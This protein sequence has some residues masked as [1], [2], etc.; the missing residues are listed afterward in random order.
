MHSGPT[1]A[2]ILTPASWHDWV[3]VLLVSWKCSLSES[4]DKMKKK[5]AHVY[6]TFLFQSEILSNKLLIIS[7]LVLA[8]IC[9]RIFLI[10]NLLT[11]KPERSPVEIFSRLLHKILAGSGVTALTINRKKN[12]FW[13]FA[14]WPYPKFSDMQL[15][16]SVDTMDL[17]TFALEFF[18]NK[19]K[20]K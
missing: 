12:K 5:A 7:R 20:K 15:S 8:K 10:L 16:N 6:L 2:W 13:V 4:V 17:H 19:W 11:G 3:N 14:I 1:L 9:I 18:N